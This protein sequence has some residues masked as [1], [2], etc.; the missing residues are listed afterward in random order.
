MKKSGLIKCP[1]CNVLQDANKK[2]CP[3]CGND[4]SKRESS[5]SIDTM[6]TKVG[7]YSKDEKILSSVG[8]R[9]LISFLVGAG[10]TKTSLM[11]TDKR[12]YGAG[13]NYSLR[14][15]T[16]ITLVGELKSLHSAGLE[17]YSNF[18]LLILGIP[19]LLAFGL[20]IIFI[21]LYFWTRH[22]HIKINF[23]GEIT[24]F[25]LRGIS[26]EEVETFIKTIMLAKEKVI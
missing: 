18:W 23:G 24:L 20:G 15:K 16:F 25:S 9:F 1:S 26:N 17:Y 3:N 19:L 4:L 14:G 21:I 10:I 6:E 8:Q 5:I 13:N 2:E 7:G 12:I 11:V 22:R